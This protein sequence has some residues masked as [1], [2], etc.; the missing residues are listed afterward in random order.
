MSAWK[1]IIH[2][3]GRAFA[4]K[5]EEAQKFNASFFFRLIIY[6]LL[7]REKNLLSAEKIYLVWWLKFNGKLIEVFRLHLKRVRKVTGCN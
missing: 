5:L 3:V 1:S 6:Q 7:D 2:L 4:C